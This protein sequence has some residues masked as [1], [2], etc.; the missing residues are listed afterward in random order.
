MDK[1]QRTE[2]TRHEVATL[3]GGCFWCL[4]AVYDDLQGVTDVVSGYSGGTV[5][6]PTYQQVCT[7]ETGHAEVIQV[8]FD[9]TVVSYREILE[10][11]FSIHDP[12]TLNRQGADEGTQYRSAIFYHSPEQKATAEQ[13]IAEFGSAGLWGN[14][15]V[16]EVTPLKA[17]YPAEEYHQ[18]YFR[19]NPTQG[20]CRAVV[21]PKVA[22]FRKQY[23]S[24]L[25]KVAGPAGH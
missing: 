2:P 22:K 18:E 19:R 1:G 7:G 8:T 14:R 23:M 20:Y 4:E 25:K 21:A 16:T 13:V 17:F 10:V 11:F 5:P 12:T 6:N 9:P 15:I 3:A 24:R